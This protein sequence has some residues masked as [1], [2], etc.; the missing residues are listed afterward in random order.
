MKRKVK[1][2]SRLQQIELQLLTVCEQNVK[3][4]TLN[5][6]NTFYLPHTKRLINQVFHTSNIL[7]T[8][9]SKSIWENFDLG[10]LYRP[11]CIQSVLTKSVKIFPCR[12]PA[13]LIK[14]E[15]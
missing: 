6:F 3:P 4:V 8:E 15:N 5:V 14:A 13:L 12:P 9:F 11:H 1:R 7:L 10:H 2:T